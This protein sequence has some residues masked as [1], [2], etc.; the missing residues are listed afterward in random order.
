MK[1]AAIAFASALCA[2]ATLPAWSTEP[3]DI[4][5]FAWKT[6]CASALKQFRID[7]EKGDVSAMINIAAMYR[8]GNSVPQDE[9]ASFGWHMRAAQTGNPMAQALVAEDYTKGYGVSVN[10]AAGAS[11]YRRAAV[12]GNPEGMNGLAGLYAA[13][14]G[15]P[16]NNVEALTWYLRAEGASAPAYSPFREASAAIAKLVKRMTPSEIAQAKE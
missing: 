16:R 3:T 12:G 2:L 6:D 14:R 1:R 9:T 10:Y 8:G 4:C 13:G 5:H 15:L 7:A 11:W